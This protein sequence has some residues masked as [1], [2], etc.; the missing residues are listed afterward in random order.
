MSTFASGALGTVKS[1]SWRVASAFSRPRRYLCTPLE[2]APLGGSAQPCSRPAWALT[3]GPSARDPGYPQAP[4]RQ[5]SVAPLPAGSALLQG[6]DKC[7]EE[8]ERVLLEMDPGSSPA[9]CLSS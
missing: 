6:S 9:S 5:G 3:Y 7:S 1:L 4:P 2:N 8:R